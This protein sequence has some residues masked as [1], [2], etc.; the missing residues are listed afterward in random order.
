[1]AKL[2]LIKKIV[3]EDSINSYNLIMNIL[4]GGKTPEIYDENKVYQKGDTVL[5][6]K[7]GV[8]TVVTIT[9]DNCTGTFDEEMVK[10]VVFTELFKD[11][12]IITQ[13][14]TIIQTKQEALSDDLATLVYELAGLLDHKLSLK[15]LYRENFKNVDGLN[16]RSGIHVPGSIQTIPE[17]GM[18]FALKQPV[19]LKTE[20]KSFKIKHF[21]ETVGLPS[22]SFK[23][24]FNALD[25]NPY[26]INANDAILSGD[27]FE[28]PV[29]EMNKEKDVP[30]ALDIWFNVEC[31]GESSLKISDL[32]V[33]FV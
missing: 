12:S 14:N 24:T 32:M 16:L 30:Y 6:L 9:K 3:N 22:I 7:D 31:R 18:D 11:S 19:E 25:A 10:E 1:M 29:E 8:Y 5:V 4:F 27:F 20:P 2:T 13:N 26:W 33:V 15:V 17:V 28:I 21:I 23:I